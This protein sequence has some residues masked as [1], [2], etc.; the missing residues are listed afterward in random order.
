MNLKK[1]NLHSAVIFHVIIGIFL[2]NHAFA[3]NVTTPMPT[4]SPSFMPSLTP[5]GRPSRK[6]TPAPTTSNKPSM[7]PSISMMPS[8]SSAPSMEPSQLP[9]SAPTIADTWILARPIL[10][11]S[12]F[13]VSI[14]ENNADG[15]LCNFLFDIIESFCAQDTIET[16]CTEILETIEDLTR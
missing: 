13:L 9:T 6:P 5:S 14:C 3:Q 12:G 15:V 10:T 11:I 1:I 8:L 4:P 7:A 2:S 16:A